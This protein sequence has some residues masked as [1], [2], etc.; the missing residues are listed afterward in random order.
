MPLLHLHNTT[1]K[2]NG[3]TI[4]TN[5]S[6]SIN[7]GEQWALVGKSGSGKT[8]LLEAIA[9]KRMITGGEVTRPENIVLVTPK[10]KFKNLSNTSDFY[11]QQRFNSIDS[12]DAQ[13]VRN[14]LALAH[15][16]GENAFW[17]LDNVVSRLKLNHLINK[18]VIKLSNGETR[19]L[20]F[21]EALLKN[22]SLLLLDSPLVGLDVHSRADFNGLLK[23]IIASGIHVVITANAEELPDGITHVATL[24]DCRIASQHT[25]A[26]FENNPKVSDS[27]RSIDKALLQKL[28]SQKPVAEFENIISMKNVLIHY[29]DKTILDHINWTVKQGERWALSGHNGAGKSTLLSLVNGDNPQAYANDIVLFDRQRGSGESIWEIKKKIGFVSPELFQYF[30]ADSSCSDVIES[31]LY[32]T[33]GL[34]RKPL[35]ANRELIANWMVLLSIAAHGKTLFRNVSD[36]VQRLCLLARA[37]IKN[38]PL[39]I[40]DEPTQGMDAR[41]RENFKCLTNSICESSNVTLIYVSH[42]AEDI[43]DCVTKRLVLENGRVVENV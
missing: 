27:G 11:Y 20:L 5:L 4:F 19:R 18:E 15:A 36:S 40:F 38:P 37:L 35:P 43:P 33:M 8:L 23:E 32:D 41:Q 17:S 29:G 12:E 30:P 31:G 1:I 10:P 3:T 2:N 21:A 25:L 24:E 39:L 26:E 6:F 34:F 14:Y 42:Y 7:Q 9:G 22:P 16:T 28:L 13:T